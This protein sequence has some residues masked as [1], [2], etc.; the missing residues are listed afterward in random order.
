MHLLARRVQKGPLIGEMRRRCRLWRM[1][2]K[3]KRERKKNSLT[4]L[5]LTQKL[6]YGELT[7]DPSEKTRLRLN[8]LKLQS[9]SSAEGDPGLFRVGENW[10][11][12]LSMQGGS[13]TRGA[14][15]TRPTPSSRMWADDNW[16]RG[17][18]HPAGAW[19]ST[20]PA[21]AAG[22]D[23][24]LPGPFSPPH[25]SEEKRAESTIWVTIKQHVCA[26]VNDLLCI[27]VCEW[28]RRNALKRRTSVRRRN[29]PASK[30]HPVGSELRFQSHGQVVMIGA[31]ASGC[32][33]NSFHEKPSWYLEVDGRIYIFIVVRT[34]SSQGGWVTEIS[35]RN[36]NS[37]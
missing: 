20:R 12:G 27:H 6:G 36:S 5:K 25:F 18:S 16:N 17:E 21:E 15:P 14:L 13:Q 9:R 34:V 23:A 30:L 4:P 37:I 3:R 32:D 2:L 8:R 31:F 7:G 19:W 33:W 35:V 24:G 29:S 28:G 10:C 1:N 11:G 26:A 22:T